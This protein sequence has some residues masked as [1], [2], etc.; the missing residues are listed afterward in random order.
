[1]IGTFIYPA[2]KWWSDNYVFINNTYSDKQVT[3][4]MA[5][6]DALDNSGKLYETASIDGFEAD[7]LTTRPLNLSF[8]AS[9]NIWLSF[10][11]QPGGLGDAPASQDS[12]ILQFYAPGEDKW[13][14]VW[15]GVDTLRRK[16]NP[17]IIRIED[18]RYLKKGFKF[19]FVNWASLSGF[20]DPSMIGNC[21]QWNI[22]YVY[23]DRNRNSADTSLPDV[24]FR[25]PLRSILR[26]MN[27][28]HGNSSGRSTSRKWVQLFR[29]ITV[30]M[31]G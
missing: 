13:H 19:R 2:S 12:L 23:L 4:G 21:D 6:M 24:A 31:T 16:F 17:A 28:C 5:T 27:Q 18:P 3:I 25:T 8:A 7:H 1:M 26:P 10:Y 22:D 29:S 11:Y 30:I 14:S 9:E 20:D 15:K